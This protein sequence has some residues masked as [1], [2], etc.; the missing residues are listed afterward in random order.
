MTDNELIARAVKAS[1]LSYSPYS[2][3]RVGAALLCRDGRVFCG[4]N[5]ENAAYPL[6]V[7]AERCAMFKAISEGAH[8]F[9]ALAIVGGR[10]GVA[11]GCCPPCG[12][13]R[14][15]MAELCRDPEFCVLLEDGQGG[16]RRFTLDEL[17]PL[18][19]EL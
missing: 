19:F 13:C 4:C 10:D 11:R 15:V 7:C 1:E 17:L 12:S 5:I 18:R 2:G 6:T 14:Q 8:D 3:F 9:V 16:I